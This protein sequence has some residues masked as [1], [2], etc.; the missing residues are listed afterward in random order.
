M[1]EFQALPYTQLRIVLHYLL[2]QEQADP[3]TGALMQPA[4]RIAEGM[5]MNRSLYARTL[6]VLVDEG[7]LKP[8]ER[9]ANI[10]YYALGERVSPST[11]NVVQLHGRTA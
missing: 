7:W 5:G 3:G 2:N 4:Q 8:M 10:T 11:S 9:Q 1:E 6:R